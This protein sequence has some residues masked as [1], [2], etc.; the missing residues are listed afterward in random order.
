MFKLSADPR[1]THEV[2]VQ[3][4]V[5]GG[6]KEQS[7]KATFRVLPLDQ[8]TAEDEDAS[9]DDQSQVNTLR[10]VV[11]GL[12]DLVDDA[13]EPVPY[14]DEIRDQLIGVPYVRIALMQTYIRAITKVK[15]GN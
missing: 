4:P 15:A 11:V 2:K 12:D 13:G 10:K 6:H 14:S 1:F 7:F 8:L 9:S 5:D 3:V